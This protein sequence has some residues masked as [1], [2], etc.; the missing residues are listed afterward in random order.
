M[1]SYGGRDE[2]ISRYYT[3]Y[4]KK[5]LVEEEFVIY[6]CVY[7]KDQVPRI[8]VTGKEKSFFAFQ[9]NCEKEG[10]YCTPGIRKSFWSTVAKGERQKLK[11]D[12]QFQVLQELKTL[13]SKNFYG[14][15]NELTEITP[16]DYAKSI[17]ESWDKKLDICS[18][19]AQLNLFEA[20]VS[21]LK[22]M[23]V[24]T[25]ASSIYFLSHVEKLKKQ[26]AED[27]VYTEGEKHTYVG[28][29]YSNMADSPIEYLTFDSYYTAQIKQQQL[30]AKGYLV[31]P[32]FSEERYF[33]A[34][35]F[36][37]VKQHKEEFTQKMKT[38]MGEQYFA[39]LLSVYRVPGILSEEERN[40]ICAKISSCFSENEKEALQL[41]TAKLRIC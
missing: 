14:I 19:I 41:Y 33:N 30:L 7:I 31:S 5:G 17:L 20:T 3:M 18:D 32:I 16:K 4:L 15:L 11:R 38:L 24:L 29:G 8:Y 10:S 35:D 1:N 34:V 9:Q 37:V 25:D 21:M 26:F 28:L 27:S 40:K 36:R 6:G 39:L 23:K 12:Y 13:Y 2:A 22:Q